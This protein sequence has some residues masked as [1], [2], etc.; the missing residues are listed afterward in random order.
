MNQTITSLRASNGKLTKTA[1]SKYV[2]LILLISGIN[3]VWGQTTITSGNT[4]AASAITAGNTITINAG[5][6]LNMDV[7]KSFASITTANSGTS[8]VSGVNALTVTGAITI[9]TSNTLSLNPSCTS[10]TLTSNWL[11]TATATISGSGTLT[12]GA[13]TIDGGTGGSNDGLFTIGSGSTV[14]CT[15]LNQGGGNKQHNFIVSGTFKISTTIAGIDNITCNTGSTFEYNGAAQNIYT[16][17]YS[18]LTLSGSSTKTSGASFSVG[19][20][21]TVGSGVTFVPGATTHV[22]SG[23]GTLTGTGTI[24]T[25]LLSATALTTQYTITTKALTGLTVDYAGAGAQSIASTASVGNYGGLATSGGS[26][27]KTLLGAITVNGDITIGTGTTLTVSGSNFAINVGGSW[28]RTGTF[29]QGTGTVTFNG[30]GTTQ[31]IGGSATT[32]STLTVATGAK[33]KND[34]ASVITTFNVN[35]TGYFI[36]NVAGA[37]PGTTRTFNAAGLPG[38]QSTIEYQNNTANTAPI[39]ASYGNLIVNISSYSSAVGS[40]GNLNSIAGD[41]RIQNTGGQELRLVSTQTTTHN[42]GGNLS[43]EGANA[44]LVINSGVSGAGT[45]IINVT[46]NLNVSNGILDLG[47]GTGTPVVNVTGGVNLSGGTLRRTGTNAVTLNVTGNWSNTGGTFTPA[48]TTVNLNGTTQSIGGTSSTTFNNLTLAGS[49]TK[50]CGIATAVNSAL[51]IGSGVV[52]NLGLFIHTAG[53]LSLNGSA[54]GTG[55]SYGGTGSIATT[56]NSTFFA[57]TLGAINVGSCGTYSLTSTA[58]ISICFGN[59]ATVTVTSTAPNL[60]VG[61]YTMFYTLTGA[62]TGISSSLMTVTVAGTGSFTT[63]TLANIGSTT[64]TIDYIRNGCVLKA[65]AANTATI[66]VTGNN[67]VGSPSSTPTLCINTVMTNITHT[68]T[69]ATGIGTATGLPTGVTAAWASNTITISGTPSAAGTFNYTIPLTGGCGATINATGTITVTP[70]DT[71]GVASSTPTLCIN[72]LMTSITHSTTGATGIGTATGLPTGV[73][74]AWASDTTT[75]SGTPTASGVF[76]YSIPLTGGCGSINATGTITVNGSSASVILGTTAICSGSGTNLQIAI[77]GGTSPYNVVYSAGSIGSYVS[78]SNIPIAP[79]S[80]VT[81]TLTSVTD[82]NGCV[83][84]GNSGSAVVTIDSTTSTNGGPWSNGSPTASKSAVFDN[85]NVTLGADFTA[86]SLTLKNSSVVIISSGADIIL[87]GALDIEPGSTFTLDNNANLLQTIPAGM[88]YANAG[89]IIVKRSS[90]ALKRLDYTLWSS[91]VTGQGVYSFS[92]F[93]FANRFYVYRTATNVYNNADVGF[94]ITGLNPDGVNGTDSN[95]VQFASA[96]GYLIRMPWDHPT[97]ATVWNGTFT[98]VPNNGDIPFTMTNGGA[99]QRFNVVGNPY[100]SPINMTQF[101]SDNSANIT[102]T[103]YFWRETNGTSANNAY[104]SWAGGTFTTNSEAQ[105]F[106][107][108]ST[109]RTGQGFVVEALNASTSLVF[110]NGQR[111]SDNANQFFRNG[112]TTND[113]VETNRFWLNLSNTSGAF[114][115]MAAGY[116]ADA[117][118]GVDVYDG[119][120]INTGNVLLNSILDTTDYTIQ[121]KALPFNATDVIPLSCKITTAGQYTIAIDH[122]DGLFTDGSQAIYLKDNVTNTEHNLQTGAYDFTSDA[123]TFTNRFEVVYQTQLG[124]GNPIF[125][126]NNVI[127]YNQNNDFVVNSGNIIMSSIKIFDIRGRLLQE[128]KDIHA[129][130]ATIKV[131]SANQVLLIQITSE[132]GEVVTKKVIR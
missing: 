58:N 40:A 48:N 130:Q 103:L 96:K 99:G 33:V 50:T 29:T 81:Y 82:A 84:I 24:R 132:D 30:N 32:F 121:G 11:S 28:T 43:V 122:V 18:N 85:T 115:Q 4:V 104:C 14:V 129:N 75:I 52:A 26:G 93:T 51:N 64:I 128:K 20:T 89:N 69:V 44:I 123:G 100:P 72:T 12:T 47:S 2:L 91:P 112:N 119:K 31:V 17:P 55:S 102:G 15:S 101:V 45:P 76:N 108:N 65:I 13:F 60:P 116:M 87:T 78:G 79:T 27:T 8:T 109:I 5:G 59:T 25:T 39:A 80:T 41:L 68:T 105:V 22:F 56:I 73:T 107:P 1:L 10:A 35:G 23:A 95:N 62:N 106:N 46:G 71:V 6:T 36:H 126:A 77:T 21:M 61:V 90:S 98:G 9:A 42:I 113:V 86:C 70:D 57:A 49:G 124:I 16:T 88:T 74:A 83:G 111:S 63:A 131:G 125:T 97:A 53:T 110:K 127:I 54:Q 66:T 37:L 94:N 19:G 92:P 3:E 38:A 114:S 34:V 7:A 117:T 120:N 67:T 118:N